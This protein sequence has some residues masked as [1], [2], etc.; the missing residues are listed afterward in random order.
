MLV[1]KI[2]TPL[3]GFDGNPIIVTATPDSTPEPFTVKVALLNCLGSKTPKDGKE[4]IEIYRLGCKL[5]EDDSEGVSPD[6]LA[7]L[8]AAVEENKPGY[9]GMIQGQLLMFL[10]N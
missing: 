8:K 3:K 10:E 7:L 2:N 6:S 5:F 4:S 1:N 9:T